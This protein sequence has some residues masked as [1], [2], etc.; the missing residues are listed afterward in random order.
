MRAYYYIDYFVISVPVPVAVAV[1]SFNFRKRD[2]LHMP[3]HT[4]TCGPEFNFRWDTFIYMLIKLENFG[5]VFVD[6]FMALSGWSWCGVECCEKQVQ[7]CRRFHVGS[8]LSSHP[9]ENE[10]VPPDP[11][12]L[13]FPFPCG[14]KTTPRLFP[15]VFFFS[16]VACLASTSTVLRACIATDDR[17]VHRQW[18]QL[19]LLQFPT[20]TYVHTHGV[21]STTSTFLPKRM[22]FWVWIDQPNFL[23]FY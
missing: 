1:F 21:L 19:M 22:W 20:A 15:W 10:T 18:Q 6:L 16:S 5:Y 13:S 14:A 9:A 2:H 23:K 12:L 17:W 3:C 8:L 11:I 4:H 7:A